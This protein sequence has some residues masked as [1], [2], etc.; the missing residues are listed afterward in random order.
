MQKKYY[1]EKKAKYT[2]SGYSLIASCSFDKS[3]N[4]KNIL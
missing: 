1:I 3:K 2:P 4:K